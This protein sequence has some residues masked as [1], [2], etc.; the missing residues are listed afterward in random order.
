MLNKIMIVVKKIILGF[1]FIYA[2]NSL[3]FSLDVNIPINFLTVSFVSVFG[4]YL[5]ISIFTVYFLM[6]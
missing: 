1:L 2:F 6:R 3:M 4:T 5:S